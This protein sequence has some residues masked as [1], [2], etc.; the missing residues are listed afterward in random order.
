MF[1]IQTKCDVKYGFE[2]NSAQNVGTINANRTNPHLKNYQQQWDF[3]DCGNPE[4]WEEQVPVSTTGTLLK[5]NL[6]WLVN[7][8]EPDVQ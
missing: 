2:A 1:R 3:Y 7:C 6:F 4:E 8:P 5:C